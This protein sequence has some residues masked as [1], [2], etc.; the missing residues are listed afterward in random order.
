MASIFK[1]VVYIISCHLSTTSQRWWGCQ[2][3]TR[4]WMLYGGRRGGELA[5]L[6]SG[7]LSCVVWLMIWSGWCSMTDWRD[8]WSRDDL[9]CQQDDVMACRRMLHYRHSGALC[10]LGTTYI[11]N[12]MTS[13]HG[14]TCCITDT[15]ARCVV[16][17]RPTLSTGWRHGSDTLA[18]LQTLW[19][20]VWSGDDLHCQQDDVMAGTRLLHYRHSGAM[21]GLG[22]SYIVNRMTSWHGD[23]CCITDTLAR[24]VVWGR[25][26]LS[27]GWRHGMETLAALQTLWRA[28]W[29]GDDLHC[30]QDDVMAWRRL[31]HYRHSGALCGLGTTY[32]VNRMTSW[33]GDAC[34]ITDTLA[35]CVVWGRP[36]LS[37]GWRHG[38]ETLAALQ[39]LWR[40]VWS[41]DDLHCQQDDV[42]ALMETLAALQTLWRDVWSGDD[43]HC[44]QDDVMAW[45]RLLHYRHSGAMCGLGTTYIVH[46]VTSWHGDACYITDTLARCVVW[47]RPTLSTG[48]RHGM[49]TLATSQ[50]LWRDVW[51]GDDLHC[52]QDDVMTDWRVVWSGDDLH[53]QQDDV[54]AWRRLPHYRHSGAMCGLGTTYIVNRM[55][56]WHGDAC[57][58]T[59]TL[60]RCV[61]WGR[62]TLST[63]W[64]HGTDGD[65]C[66]ITDTLARCVVWGRPTLSTGWRHGMETL[67]ALQTLWRDVWSG[68]D[69]HCQ[70]DDVMAWRRLL[71]YRHSG[72]MC[73]L[74]T[75]YIVNRMT[76]WHGDACYITDTLARCVV[77][78]RPT[79][80]TGWRHGMQ[81]LAA[82]Q[83]LWRAVWSG[84]DLHCQQDD[85]MAWTRLLHY[86]HSGAMCGLGTTY[87]VNR[88]TSWHG[89]ACCITDTLARC[90]V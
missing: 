79:L 19:R 43:L 42:M 80:S 76:S 13:W 70:Q 30:Q 40:A 38:V 87:I 72:A 50:T 18:T 21:C 25:P 5:V 64:R 90:V 51:S 29:S 88:M 68:D 46:R 20:D 39:T 86:R 34:R 22:T 37:T 32:I 53:C 49:E 26:T 24:C 52:Q 85:V 3:A 84:D 54:M 83:T 8:V 9:H 57:C 62:P 7:V 58:I 65:A 47:G 67:A 59:D 73:G 61:V 2:L 60:A 27:T 55:T 89:H 75:T 10:G 11:V 6:S 69:L 78:G 63:G 77:W 31:L 66:C 16:W 74:G 17:G 56:S 81:T 28:V 45:T 41:G 35:R 33:H 14:D 1:S 12:R 23:A 71:H 36:T 48:W 44:Q 15:L 4:V 82:L